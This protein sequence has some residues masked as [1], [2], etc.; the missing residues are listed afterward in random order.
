MNNIRTLIRKEFSQFFRDKGNIRMLL[1]MPVIQ[2]LILPF[3]ANYEVKNI[4]LCVVDHDHS[5]QV[6]QMIQKIT[7]SGYISL[8]GYVERYDEALKL[9]E[10]DKAD[11][12]IEI[13][14]HFEEN[15]IKNNEVSLAV[16]VNAVNGSRASIGGQYLQEILRDYNQNIRA[17]W[18]QFPKFNPAPIIQIERAYWYNPTMNYKHFMVPGIL[19]ILLTMVGANMSALNFVKE[20]ELG[21]IEQ[22]NVSPIKK[23]EF[24]L[25]KLIPFWIMG[26]VVL[27]IGL[28]IAYFVYGI[29]PQ[30][31][32]F[33][34]YLFSSFYLLVVLAYGLLISTYVSTQQQTM[35]ISFFFMMVFILMSGLYTMIDSMPPWA[36]FVTKLNPVAYF[37]KVNRMVI[38]KGSKLSD[39]L[40]SIYA[41]II[42]ATVLISWAI[43]NYRKKA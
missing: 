5:P 1:M 26:Q 32:V 8:V 30:G 6:N 39:I 24:I 13:L 36:Q 20:K 17:K 42:M 37:V 27:S 14:P 10:Q 2:L 19:V 15:L 40:P 7:S 9:F 28:S 16:S 34:I 35:L 12:I 38:M 25:G 11:I 41:M 23:Y 43:L 3:A 21:T 33:V 18:I 22:I 4:N 29:I 31:S